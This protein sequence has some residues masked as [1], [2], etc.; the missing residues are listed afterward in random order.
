[1]RKFL[2]AFP[3]FI[4]PFCSL[5]QFKNVRLAEQSDDGRH[6]PVEPS[7]TINKINPQ[8]I[9]A[10][11]RLDRVVATTDGGKTWT[12]S[13]LNSPFGVYGDP[14]VISNSKGD[15]FYFHLAD[16][17]GKG[18]SNE[19]WLDR[20]VCQQSIDEGKSWTGGV[21]IGNNPPADQDKAWPAVHPKKNFMC[22]TWTQFDK[23][24][25]KDPNCQSNILFSKS[26]NGNRWS[27]PV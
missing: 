4:I 19:A 27:M 8:N 11:I 14:T 13:K 23:Y 3:L 2:F 12:E 18:Q 1:M 21:S 6:P 7:I 15:I 26:N 5:S 17:S 25:S 9:V 10:G 20:I 22:V 24:G 16:P